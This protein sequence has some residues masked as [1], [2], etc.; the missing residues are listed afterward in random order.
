MLRRRRA[1]SSRLS[2]QCPTQLP[3]SEGPG[4]QPDSGLSEPA[5]GGPADPRD[6]ESGA[7][8]RSVVSVPQ[9]R[10]VRPR[11]RPGPGGGDSDGRTVRVPGP[12]LQGQLE[13]LR[14]VGELDSTQ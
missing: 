12:A 7:A 11:G 9:R 8:G 5:A 4:G 2:C 6:S 1:Q 10:R 13:V 14:A 3:G